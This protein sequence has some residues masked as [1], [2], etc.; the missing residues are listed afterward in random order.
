MTLYF[1]A[2]EASGD[3]HGAGLL[4]ALHSLTPGLRFIGRGGP[5]MK[6]IAGDEFLDWS[7][8]SAVLGLWEVLKQ[9]GYFRRE[10][11]AAIREIHKTKPDA[12]VLIDY[13]GFNL[14]LACALRERLPALKIIY[15][16]SP[17]VWAWNRRRIPKMARCLDLMLCIFPFEEELYNKS[18]LRTIF[19]GHPMT[20]SLGREA[21][22]VERDPN[23]IAL[24]PGSR[25]R[26]VRKI[27]PVML[28]AAAHVTKVKP[29][30]TFAVVAASP[31]LA[32]E[33]EKFTRT[34][35]VAVQVT[36]GDPKAVMREAWAGLV[37]SGTATLEAALMGMPFLLV[38][39]LA[40]LS[41]I[42]AKIVIKIDYIG[43]P[44]VL[45][46]RGIVP[47]FIQHKA[48]PSAI[49][50]ALLRLIEDEQAR[51][52]MQREFNAVAASLGDVEPSTTAARAILQEIGASGDSVDPRRT[53]Q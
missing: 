24:L 37:A 14:R 32:R 16:I 49:A 35:P 18:G 26:E 50:Q 29:H 13:P 7:E 22:R 44:N 34:A 52:E 11:R 1:V 53:G 28:E 47:E 43:M 21:A 36:I 3:A 17:Q 23:L 2:G 9:Y 19:V 25:A 4:A 31:P 27:L 46:G 48:R 42:A 30:L 40:W 51:S 8:R 39:R 33:I 12:V 41:Y 20:S 10:F 38:Y 6:Q 5:R 15:Y 45:A